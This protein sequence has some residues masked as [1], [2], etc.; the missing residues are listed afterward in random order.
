MG[1]MEIINIE[2]I[3]RKNEIEERAIFYGLE[4]IIAKRWWK[5]F[6]FI[7]K[8]TPS[9]VSFFDLPSQKLHG[10]LTRFEI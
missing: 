9:F 3:L 1:Y 5:L 6:A 2:E 4:E 8:I 10:V 7:K